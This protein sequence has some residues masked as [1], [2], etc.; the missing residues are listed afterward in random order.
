MKGQSFYKGSAILL[1][2]V[3]VTK[4]MGL[5]YKLMLT[6]LLGGTGMACYQSV[7][8]A[9]TPVYAIAIGG[10]P[11]AVAIMTAENFALERY[12]NARKIR[13]TALL[14]FTLTG[15]AA[16]III[17][18]CSGVISKAL[19]GSDRM[20]AGLAAVSPTVVLCCVI[21]VYRG[22]HEGLCDMVPTAVSEITETLFKLILGLAFAYIAYRHTKGIYSTP[23][24]LS[25]TAAA[26]IFGVSMSSLFA[27]IYLI[28]RLRIKGDGIS[29][30][31]L[32]KDSCTDSRKHIIK[33]LMH[34]AFPI[35]MTAA[36]ST[37]INTIDLLTV[38]PMLRYLQERGMINMNM[39]KGSGVAA[40]DTADF[41]YGSYTALALTVTGIIPGFTAMLGKPA[42]P[43]VSKAKATGDKAALKKGIDDI[44]LLSSLIAFP[45]S[46]GLAVFPKEVLG[47][48]FPSRGYEVAVSAEPFAVLSA[49]LVFGCMLPPVFALLQAAGR[50]RSCVRIMLI[51]CAVK[52]TGNLTLMLIPGLGVTG[53]AVSLVLAD[54]A[55]LFIAVYIL[56]G[57]TG[58]RTDIKRCI[59]SPAFAAVLCAA[60]AR[61]CYDRLFGAFSGGGAR[62]ILLISVIT[63]GI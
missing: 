6:N 15:L 13:R 29:P 37:L 18:L 3:A 49:G 40:K 43:A 24:A 55:A 48:L 28:L 42:L 7:Y 60:G 32:Q 47:F 36:I 12:K 21:S 53:A 62:I 45:A 33:E 46:F 9:F 63:G 16:S 52:L 51:S 22:Y 56:R 38:P 61:L 39:L 30:R 54:M 44:A 25:L 27:C 11:S 57:C 26:S 20:T 41:I 5:A 59:L 1:F 17:A 2:M 50:P 10:I 8:A 34:Y 14:F 23:D 4:V 31:Q 19:T 35:A 58:V